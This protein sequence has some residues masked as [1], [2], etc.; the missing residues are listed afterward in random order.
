MIDS[1]IN[2][3]KFFSEKKGRKKIDSC[4]Y[5]SGGEL[6]KKGDIVVDNVYKPKNVYGIANGK[7]DFKKRFYNLSFDN[8]KKNQFTKF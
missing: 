8:F 7:G 5:V 4:F 6:G 1:Q 2:Y 3:Y